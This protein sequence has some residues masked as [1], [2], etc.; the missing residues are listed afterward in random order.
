M[1]FNS[2][3]F[4]LIFIPT[5]LLGYFILNFFKKYTVSQCFL[6]GMS[7][8]FYGYFNYKYLFIIV[9]SIFINYGLYIFIGKFRGKPS[10]KVFMIIGIIVNLGILGF[11]K[12]TDFFIDTVNH[13][14][15]SDLPLLHIL[16][17]LG[18]SFFT[19][20]QISF[21]IDTYRGEV[22][23][24]SFIHYASFV[25][26]FPQLV[27][28]P[29]VTHDEL[30]TQFTDEA[31]KKFNTDNMVKGLFMFTMGLS[32][33]VLIADVFGAIVNYGYVAIDRLNTVS[34]WI[35]ILCYTFQIYFDFSGYSDMAIGLAKMFNIELPVNF[36]SPYKSLTINEFWDRWHMTLTRFLTKYV[37]IPLGGNRK[38]VA[39]MFVNIFIVFLLSG[40]WHGAGWTFIL[41]GVLHGVFSMIMKALKKHTEKISPVFLWLITFLFINVTWVFFRATSIQDALLVLQKAFSW[42]FAPVDPII[43]NAFRTPELIQLLAFADVEMKFP[44]IIPTLYMAVAFIITLAMPNSKKLMDKFKPN[45]ITFAFTLILFVWSFLS[46]SGVSTFLYFNF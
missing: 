33:K 31:K 17:P 7:L 36:D 25:A 1:L 37:Y 9:I 29:I 20:Q 13:V 39:R 22:N 5:C 3:L 15:K 41:W 14:F 42:N 2:F 11:F 35:V 4:I 44:N 16:L 10:S 24:Y 28:G 38:G 6:L 18:I 23:K 40:I 8:W 46:L 43:I 30:I 19:F 34:A 26:F 21:I 27:A 32:K 12:Y 45:V